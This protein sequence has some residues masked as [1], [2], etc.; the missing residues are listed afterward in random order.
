[1][2]AL[3]GDELEF[4]YANM[5]EESLADHVLRVILFYRDATHLFWGSMTKEACMLRACAFLSLGSLDTCEGQDSGY[6]PVTQT[7]GNTSGR[8]RS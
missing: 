3:C 7:S 2:S 1:M 4:S 6:V 8:L 5:T